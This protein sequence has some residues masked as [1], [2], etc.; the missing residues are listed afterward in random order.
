MARLFGSRPRYGSP[1]AVLAVA[2]LAALLMTDSYMGQEWL[3]DVG[4]IFL[5]IPAI[6]WIG[7]VVELPKMLEKIAAILGDVSY[8][9][10]AVH[11]PLL[12]IATF[13]LIRTLHISSVIAAIVFVVS[14][15]LF[16]WA[17]AIQFDAPVRKWL[18]GKL[19]L[20]PTALPVE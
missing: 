15:F 7:I 2:A 13:V 20:R 1:L 5:V 3:Y 16:S 6:L 14:V 11:M 12:Q 19:H 10:Y 18:S 8:P 4:A 17:L 9:I